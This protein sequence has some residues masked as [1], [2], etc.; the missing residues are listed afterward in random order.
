[1]NAS[2]GQTNEAGL[3]NITG[4]WTNELGNGF[5]GAF[6][7]SQISSFGLGGGGYAKNSITMDASRCSG[8]YGSSNTVLPAS[9]DAPVII[10]LGK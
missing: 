4:S 5:T 1:M 8:I 9:V 3:P 7:S 2:A 6:S 10:Y